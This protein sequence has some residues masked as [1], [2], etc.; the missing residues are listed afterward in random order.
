MAE[1]EAINNARRKINEVLKKTNEQIVVGWRPGLE[2]TR[3]EG[4]VWVGLDDKKWTIKNGVKQTVTKL[5][6][7][8]TPWYCPECQKTMGHRF[9]IKFWSLR[10]KC[11]DCVIKEE[12]EMRR[13]GTWKEYEERKIKENYIASLKDRIAELQNLYETVTAPE[14]I[15]ADDTRI[16]MIEKWHVDI[17][18]VKADIMT[19]IEELNG[20]LAEVETGE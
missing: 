20:F 11:M 16:L 3:Q 5:D 2:P 14:V 9:D 4:D 13:L 17:D 15:H 8:K 1:H 7:A 18:K 19:D 12:T 10:G 6:A